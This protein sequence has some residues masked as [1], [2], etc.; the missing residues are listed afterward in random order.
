MCAQI[1]DDVAF[2]SQECLTRCGISV[3]TQPTNEQVPRVSGN[4]FPSSLASS[5][6]TTATSIPGSATDISNQSREVNGDLSS[7]DVIK[8]GGSSQ[9]AP[10]ADA[11]VTAL[12]ILIALMGAGY[13]GLAVLFCLYR[14]RSV[15]IGEQS[16]NPQWVNSMTETAALNSNFDKYDGDE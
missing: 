11:T 1:P 9:R 13:V 12:T 15:R 4:A 8:P 5:R 2:G 10:G 7:D 3:G 6:T 16:R 14:R